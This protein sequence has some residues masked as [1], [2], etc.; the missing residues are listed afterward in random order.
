MKP[1]EM[2]GHIHDLRS[3]GNELAKRLWEGKIPAYQHADLADRGVEDFVHVA[4]GAGEVVALRT[5]EWRKALAGVMS[6][7]GSLHES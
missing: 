7:R 2:I 3:L 5:P 1:A 6:V 4:T